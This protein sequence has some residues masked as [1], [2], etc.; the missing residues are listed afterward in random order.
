M[1]LIT[2]EWSEGN[3]LEGLDAMNEW[4]FPQWSHNM[5]NKH[6]SYEIAVIHLMF[7][8]ST[9]RLLFRLLSSKL[10]YFKIFTYDMVVNS[11][12]KRY[13]YALSPRR[14]FYTREIFEGSFIQMT[15]RLKFIQRMR[16]GL[17]KNAFLGRCGAPSPWPST[18]MLRHQ[19]RVIHHFKTKTVWYLPS[20]A[21]CAVFSITSHFP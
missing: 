11:L 10:N 8:F 1:S 21:A 2:D 4:L 15:L 12:Q 13:A 14:Q 5:S 18:F 6:M 19:T 3:V 7:F 20:L 16:P 17:N 9:T